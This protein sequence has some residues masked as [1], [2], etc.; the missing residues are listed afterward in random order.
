MSLNMIVFKKTKTPYLKATGLNAQAD[1]SLTS[2]MSSHTA[3]FIK[4]ETPGR[5]GYYKSIWLFLD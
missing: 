5:R 2:I 3:P 1:I 4:K